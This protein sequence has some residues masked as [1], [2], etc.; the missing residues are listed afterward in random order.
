MGKFTL[1]YPILI[2]ERW[3]QGRKPIERSVS[4]NTAVI[5][6]DAG[7]RIDV[8]LQPSTGVLTLT[9]A[10]IPGDVRKIRLDMLI[11]FGFANGGSWKAGDG[12]ETAFPAEKPTKP[13]LLQATAD[14]F[15]LRDFE[16]ARLRLAVPPL[17]FQQLT[18]NREWGW[19]VFA[20]QCSASY[21]AGAS[22]LQVKITFSPPTVPAQPLVDRFGQS[23]RIDFPAK[24]KSEDELKKD[25]QVDAEYYA[26]LHPP[27]RDTYGGLPDSREKLS[28][29]ATGFFHVEKKGEWIL[30][31]PAGNAFFHLGVCGFNPSDDYTY[32]KGREQI[33]EWLPAHDGEFESAFH[34]NSYWNPNVFSFHLVN[35]IRKYGRPY[36]P[37]AYT[38]RMIERV[39]KWGFNSAGAF[40]AG[41]EGAR[42][43]ARFPYVASLPLS[44]WEGFPEVPGAQGAFDPFDEKLRARCDQNFAERIA[45]HANDPLLIGYFLNNEPLY[46]NLP[47]AIAA[48]NSQHPCKRRL[49]QMLEEKYKT[50]A[51]FNRAW[52]TA[53]A[54]FAEV[55]ERGLPVKTDAAKADMQ[56]FTGLFLE[57]YFRLVADTFHK[58]DTNHLLIGNRFQPGTINNEQLCRISGQYMDVV[59][60]NYYTYHLDKDFL[61]RI[62]GWTGGRPMFL[63]EFY[64]DSPKDSGLPGGGKDVNSQ[65]ERGLAYRNYVEQAA[66]LGFVVGIEW[67]TLIDQSVSGRFFDKYNGENGNTGL[68]AVTDRPWKVMLGEMM[69]CNDHIYQIQFGERAPFVFDDPR[70]KAAAR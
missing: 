69:Q 44:V 42:R 23:T 1:N 7:A 21:H 5:K 24:V 9:P 62:Y 52:E 60:F 49:A 32:F 67:F 53:F 20:W 14:S 66:T 13:H 40:G 34:P 17:S 64:Y 26:N 27:T 19:K 41:D 54:S 11:D 16:G 35:T 59:S 31:D 63:S 50:L 36:E 29:K 12:P 61:K 37:A 56:E 39:R 25:V 2:G 68:I 48:L 65:L 15:A 3:D 18:D 38:T 43:Q 30:V 6:F 28:L 55:A 57:T 22:P 70:F 51:A 58:Y 4:G 45:P 47:G 46:E 8:A 10:H 33:Y